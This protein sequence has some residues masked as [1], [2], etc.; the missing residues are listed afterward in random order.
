[1][2]HISSTPTFPVNVGEYRAYKYFCGMRRVDIESMPSSNANHPPPVLDRWHARPAGLGVI[3]SD[4]DFSTQ[5]TSE[6]LVEKSDSM[7]SILISPPLLSI[8]WFC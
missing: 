4:P 8:L 1:M 6:T 5:T 2:Q 3:C 7:Y